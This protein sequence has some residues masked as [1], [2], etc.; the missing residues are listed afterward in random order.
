VN[1]LEQFT[2]KRVD[3]WLKEVVVGLGLCPFAAQ[4]T[5]SGLVEIVVCE[6][7]SEEGILNCLQ[8]QFLRLEKS[9]P[10]QLETILVAVPQALAEFDEYNQF[11]NSVDWLLDRREW[12]GIFQVASFHP[13]YQFSG[14]LPHDK[15]NLTNCA[16]VPLFHLLREESLAKAIAGYGDTEP[17]PRNN[18]ALVESLGEDQIRQLFPYWDT[19]RR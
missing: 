13:Q 7:E 11:L 9:A 14:T 16:P 19:R 1:E 17:I 8:Q 2:L 5:L 3:T 4:P 10:E 15:S 18:I 12:Q 6:A